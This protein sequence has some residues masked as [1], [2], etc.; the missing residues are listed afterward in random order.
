MPCA[1]V[2]AY[3]Y[4]YQ[5]GEGRYD[6]V[7]Q[8]AKWVRQM[9][10]WIVE[11]GSSLY[12]V[13]RRLDALGVPTKQGRKRW[14][15]TSVR[16]ILKNSIYMGEWHWNKTQEWSNRTVTTPRKN[17]PVLGPGGY[18][19]AEHHRQPRLGAYLAGDAHKFIRTH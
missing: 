14:S 3:G 17:P 8:E 19:R 10:E 5:T 2:S 7:E 4:A 12:E 1:G 15:A 9:L 6:V 11:E 16:Y 18:S 13:V